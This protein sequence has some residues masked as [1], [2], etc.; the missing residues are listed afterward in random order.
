M[1]SSPVHVA[2]QADVNAVRGAPRRRIALAAVALAVAGCASDAWRPDPGFDAFLGQVQQDCRGQR[3]GPAP[4]DQ[5]IASPGSRE[6][7]YFVDQTS[8]L[9]AG[10]ITREA[11]TASV[12]GILVGRPS[13]P[14]IRCVLDRMP[15]K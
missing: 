7:G 8:R 1:R 2:K 12:T 4:V 9:Y 14:G 13:D 5:L 3:I 6:G 11:W 15:A 10:R